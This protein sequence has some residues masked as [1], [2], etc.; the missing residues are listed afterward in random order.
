MLLSH[1]RED[2]EKQLGGSPIYVG[3]ATFFVKRWGT[4]E[5]QEQLKEIR[6]ALFGPF[7]KAQEGD[8]NLVF[9]EWLCW[10]VTNWENVNTEDGEYKFSAKNARALFRDEHYFL[11]L[12]AELITSAMRFENYLFDEAAEDEEELKKP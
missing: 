6:R 9:A 7:H 10:A 3:D 12:N 4:K 1:Y 5:S 11:S 8:D 2:P